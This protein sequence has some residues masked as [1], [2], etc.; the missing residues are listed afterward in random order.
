MQDAQKLIN[1]YIDFCKHGGEFLHSHE[2]RHKIGLITLE[3]LIQTS[4]MAL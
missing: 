2:H 3:H 4:Q 1:L